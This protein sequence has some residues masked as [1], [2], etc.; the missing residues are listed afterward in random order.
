[1]SDKRSQ[2]I[3]SW[4]EAEQSRGGGK[5]EKHEEQDGERKSS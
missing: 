3:Y 1:M 2:S 4:T 5:T